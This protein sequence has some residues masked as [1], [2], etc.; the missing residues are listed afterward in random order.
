[1]IICTWNIRGYNHLKRNSVKVLLRTADFICLPETLRDVES[2]LEWASSNA[3][4]YRT[5][6]QPI[7][8]G[9]VAVLSRPATP[10]STTTTYS[11][12]GFQAVAGSLNGLPLVAC[13]V[14]PNT[15]RHE[16]DIFLATITKHLPGPCVLVGDLN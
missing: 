5:P 16:Y 15:P 8:R 13:Y 10:F 3:A 6:A 9:G 14:H 7:L 2:T 12:K 11:R 1:M 4:V